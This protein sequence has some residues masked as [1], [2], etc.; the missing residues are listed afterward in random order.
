MNKCTVYEHELLE[1]SVI[2]GYKVI[3]EHALYYLFSVSRQYLGYEVIR[4]L[5]S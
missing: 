3:I 5:T 1:S 4:E 2:N